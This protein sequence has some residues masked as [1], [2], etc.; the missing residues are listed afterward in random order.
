MVPE[1]ESVVL[2]RGWSIAALIEGVSMSVAEGSVA[3]GFLGG[4]IIKFDISDAVMAFGE[5]FGLTKTVLGFGFRIVDGAFVL[6]VCQSS[7]SGSPFHNFIYLYL[8]YS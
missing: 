1:D 3:F 5:S 2:V 6:F 7:E 8:I 4:K